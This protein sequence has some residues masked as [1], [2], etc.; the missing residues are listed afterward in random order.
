MGPFAQKQGRPVGEGS[1]GGEEAWEAGAGP[2]LSSWRGT[3]VFF[4]SKGVRGSRG[5]IWDRPKQG[6]KVCFRLKK[7]RSGYCPENVPEPGPRWGA[8]L[9]AGGKGPGRSC[10]L[11]TFAVLA[12][13]SELSGDPSVRTGGFPRRPDIG[14]GHAVVTLCLLEPQLRDLWSGARGH[15]GASWGVGPPR[16]VSCFSAAP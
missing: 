9:G 6:Q 4:M 3:W 14:P 8:S 5:V 1:W 10:A 13:G 15:R 11:L 16:P 2:G 7:K 12:A